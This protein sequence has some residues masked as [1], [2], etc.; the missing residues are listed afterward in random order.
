MPLHAIRNVYVID[1]V[2]LQESPA[3]DVDLNLILVNLQAL[4]VEEFAFLSSSVLIETLP[5]RK[6]WQAKRHV[7]V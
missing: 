6:A 1:A 4:N 7:H 3:I 5:L 2:R